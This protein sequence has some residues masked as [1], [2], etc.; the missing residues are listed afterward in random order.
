M[1]E[2]LYIRLVYTGCYEE[3][4]RANSLD[5]AKEKFD[6]GHED[7]IDSSDAME[8]SDVSDVWELDM[9]VEEYYDE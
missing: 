1:S 6:N 4:V 5:E 8:C 2:K 9:D 7:V 3:I